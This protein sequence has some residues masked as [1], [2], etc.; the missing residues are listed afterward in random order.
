MGPLGVVEHDELVELGLGRGERGEQS[1]GEELLAQR[2]VEPLDLAGRSGAARCGQPVRDPVLA[3]DPIE[4]R[5]GVTLAEAI[6]EDLAVEF[7]TDVKSQF[8]LFYPFSWDE[9]IDGALSD[10]FIRRLA[11]LLIVL[12]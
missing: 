4:E 12:R 1:S 6:R 7:L 8:A 9:P 11:P 5:L 10:S 3:T 2:A